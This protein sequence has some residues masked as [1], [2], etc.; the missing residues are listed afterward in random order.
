MKIAVIGAGALGG[1]FGGLLQKTGHDVYYLVRGNT[2]AHLDE[3]GLKI[4]GPDY[5][6][7]LDRVTTFDSSEAGAAQ[8]VASHGHPEVV[9]LG[10]RADQVEGI[11]PVVKALTGENTQVVTMQNGVMAP[12][13]VA[14]AVG[15]DHTCPGIVRVFNK[16]D[17]PG[18]VNYMGGGARFSFARYDNTDNTVIL[19]LR[20]A[21]AATGVSCP[22]LDDINVELWAKAMFMVPTGTLGAV[23]GQP[24]G[25]VRTQLRT[26]LIGIIEEIYA[27]ARACQIAVPESQIQATVDLVDNWREDAM[28]SMQRDILAGRPSEIDVMVG[29]VVQIGKEA[30]VQMP[31]TETAYHFG[32]LLEKQHRA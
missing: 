32:S 12:R 23:S 26:E 15:E 18:V 25:V 22:S 8:L 7:S 19:A 21:V 6:T 1:F 31:R 11:L 30:G 20:E 24:A 27:A 16:L 28:T 29:G 3:Y 2:K 17:G 4:V 10:V 14:A 5:E 9:L 13:Q